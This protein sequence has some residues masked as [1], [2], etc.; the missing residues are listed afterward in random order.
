M[1]N[2]SKVCPSVPEGTGAVKGC[3]SAT[4]KG[5][6][7]VFAA[8][9]DGVTCPSDLQRL[10]QGGVGSRITPEQR[11]RVF[12]EIVGG[13]LG[14]LKYPFARVAALDPDMIP[15]IVNALDNSHYFKS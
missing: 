9:L 14:D 7:T 11:H 10:V 1:S 8:T 15:A 13:A 3:V 12:K 2:I 4:T 6:S 5:P